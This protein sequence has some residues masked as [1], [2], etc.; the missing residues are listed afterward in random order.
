M[1][2]PLEGWPRGGVAILIIFM[3]PP[4]LRTPQKGNYFRTIELQFQDF[5]G[6]FEFRIDDLYNIK[7]WFV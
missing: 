4:A 6:F 3:P 2:L 1:T 7:A 5:D